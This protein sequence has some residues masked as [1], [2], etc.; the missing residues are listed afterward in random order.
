MN[1]QNR[2][3]TYTTGRRILIHHQK[4]RKE[5]RTPN[6]KFEDEQPVW[7][8]VEPP[9]DESEERLEFQPP[10]ERGN[11]A[12]KHRRRRGRGNCSGPRV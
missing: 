4:N 7:D 11:I 8:E 2:K 9:R 3:Q 6:P 12:G 1:L 5:G 10:A